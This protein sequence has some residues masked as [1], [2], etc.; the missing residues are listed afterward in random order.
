MYVMERIG[1]I[2][3]ANTESKSVRVSF[4]VPNGIVDKD[5][6]PDTHYFTIDGNH[7]S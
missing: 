6:E 2:T 4:S 7:A 1:V 5:I 3:D